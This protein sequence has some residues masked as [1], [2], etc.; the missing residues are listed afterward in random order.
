M[1]TANVSVYID[2]K[3]EYTNQLKIMLNTHII[4]ILNNI[5]KQTYSEC[6]KTKNTEILVCF[7]NNISKIAEWNNSQI[8]KVFDAL[9]NAECDWIDD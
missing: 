1:N 5:Y 2:A 6:I 3:V 7:Q 4:N 9:L 8:N